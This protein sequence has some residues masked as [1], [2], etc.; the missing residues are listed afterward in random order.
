MRRVMV[1]GAQGFVGSAVVRRFSRTDAT[2]IPVTR[3]NYAQLRGTSCDVLVECACNSKKFLSDSD[4]R[5]EFELSVT[6][7][8][9]SLCDF[10]AQYHIHVSS[11]DVYSD[12]DSPATTREDSPIDASRTS[13][14]GL[15]KLLAEQLV[16]HYAQQWLIVR[17][18]GMVGPGLRKNP[19]YD[20]LHNMPLRIHPDSQYQFMHTDAVADAICQLFQAGVSGEILNVCG[21]GLISPR[22]IAHIAGKPLNL[23]LEKAAQPRIVHVSTD[24]ASRRIAIPDTRDAIEGFLREWQAPA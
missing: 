8:L 17:L 24:K 6:H 22:E 18:A 5:A 10:P 9:H 14:Y 7:R 1:V 11:V 15:H 2:L 16:R 12:L 13:N 21:R 19:V 3:Q 4:P 23:T 20:I